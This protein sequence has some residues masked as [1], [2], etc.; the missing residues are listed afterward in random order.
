MPYYLYEYWSSFI[1]LNNSRQRGFEASPLL[2][3]EIIT[4]SKEVDNQVDLKTFISI[5]Q[6]MD[7]TF[8]SLCSE[9]SKNKVKNV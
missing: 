4:Y 1:I 9:K 3:S 2:L 6:A 7:S 5:I 8:L